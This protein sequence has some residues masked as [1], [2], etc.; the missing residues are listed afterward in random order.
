ME[1]KVHG[2]TCSLVHIWVAFM[3]WISRLHRIGHITADD[4]WYMQQ[5]HCLP[6]QEV[7]WSKL[8]NSQLKCFWVISIITMNCSPR[9]FH[10]TMTRIEKILA[11]NYILQKIASLFEWQYRDTDSIGFFR[12]FSLNSRLSRLNIFP[13]SRIF[14][15]A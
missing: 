7:Q 2:V 5:I 13:K 9:I 8:C 14:L 4:W 10:L 6:Q 11:S 3:P 1:F 12:R 15:Y